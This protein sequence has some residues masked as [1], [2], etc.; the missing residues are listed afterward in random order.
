MSETLGDRSVEDMEAFLQEKVFG[1]KPA[2]PSQAA[3]EREEEV[4]HVH[5]PTEGEDREVVV[6][7]APPEAPPAPPPVAPPPVPAAP[8]EEVPPEEQLPEEDTPVEDEYVAWAKRTYGE[9]PAQW[10][11]AAREK[12]NH[13]QRVAREKQAAEQNAQ[14]WAEYAQAIESQSRRSASAMPMSTAEEE[15][16]ESAVLDPIGRARDA[17]YSGNIPL[18]NAVINRVAEEDAGLAA[19][20]GTQVQMELAQ[21]AQMEQA[22][23]QRTQPTMEHQLASSFERLGIDL[24]ANGPGMSAKIA[25]LGE[26]HPY[27]QA[28]LNGDDIQR[29][30]G[31]Q[32][33]HDLTRASTLTTRRVS[34]AVQQENEMRREAMVVQQGGI[35][36]PPQ[37]PKRPPLLEAMK[38][39]WREAGQWSDE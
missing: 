19:R 24:A 12:E 38:Q 8:E 18:Y 28:I 22:Q 25:E 33:V 39:E 2:S 26:F 27:V 15:W 32:A 23:Q 17:A 3:Q 36:P 9:D 37:A 16:V 10:A 34:P 20:V 6:P 31:V 13:V 7:D 5:R 29:D 4:T 1:Q 11:K 21:Y 30:L 35:T 14:E